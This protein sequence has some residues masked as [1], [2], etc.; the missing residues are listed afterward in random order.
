M[1]ASRFGLRYETHVTIAPI[2]TRLVASASAASDVQHSKCNPSR[3]LST[4]KK[5]SSLYTAS[6]PS[7]SASIHDARMRSNVPSWG[8]A[9]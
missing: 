8:L 1:S 7:A 5:W 3:S 6:A 2:S 9:S 4:G